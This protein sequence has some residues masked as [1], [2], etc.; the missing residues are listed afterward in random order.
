[1]SRGD[2][3]RVERDYG[4]I[5]VSKEENTGAITN[6]VIYNYDSAQKG[7]L[8]FLKTVL[9]AYFSKKSQYPTTENKLVLFDAENLEQT[10]IFKELS[11]VL[12]TLTPLFPY[13]DWKILTPRFNARHGYRSD[14]KTYYELTAVLDDTSDPECVVEGNFCIYR[15]RNGE[16]VSKK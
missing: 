3:W 7:S 13:L 14:G 16:V 15:I 9:N 4:W 1:M 5:T 12:E 2:L 8:G 10:I 11:P 6:V